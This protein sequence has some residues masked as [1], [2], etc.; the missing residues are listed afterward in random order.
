MCPCFKY[1]KAEGLYFFKFIHEGFFFSFLY[2]I[3]ESS[4]LTVSRW[5]QAT[6]QGLGHATP[7]VVKPFCP[8]SSPVQAAT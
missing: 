6:A 5:L 2:L 3:L 7:C 4:R 8:Y 1:F